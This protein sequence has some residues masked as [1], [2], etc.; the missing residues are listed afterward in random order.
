MRKVKNQPE[1]PSRESVISKISIPMG[2]RKSHATFV[3][4]EDVNEA[5]LQV[6]RTLPTKI[7]QDPSLAPFQLENERVTGKSAWS[8]LFSLYWQCFYRLSFILKF[9]VIGSSIF[10]EDDKYVDPEPGP[11]NQIEM[12]SKDSGTNASLL[13]EKEWVCNIS[14]TNVR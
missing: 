7:R 10:D 9:L 8:T 3:S 12:T 5:S 11:S 6:W 2:K 14:Q 13:N 4:P 1:S